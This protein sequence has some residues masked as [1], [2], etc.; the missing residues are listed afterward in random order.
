[1]DSINNLFSPDSFLGKLLTSPALKVGLIGSG[2]I[3]NI[4]ANRARNQVLSSEM[5]Q[6]NA[7]NKL[8]PAQIVSGISS[9]QHPLNSNLVKSVGNTV[10]G[11][12]AERGLSQAPGI[13]AQAFAQGLAPYQLQEQQ[14]AQDAFFKKLGLPISARPSPFGPFPQ[15]TNIS[16]L[17]QSLM[18]QFM[19]LPGKIASAGNQVPSTPPGGDINAV[20]ASILAGSTG[21]PGLIPSPDTSSPFT[22]GATP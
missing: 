3:G 7:L 18:Q 2:A 14:L 5:A 10:S 21:I 16:Q 20:L 12:L 1:M 4:M 19:G 6:M 9:L 8:T 15:T 11:Q 22:G 17:W 13:Q